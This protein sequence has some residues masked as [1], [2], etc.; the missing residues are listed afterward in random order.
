MMTPLECVARQLAGVGGRASLQRARV[1]LVH[2]LRRCMSQSAPA[3]A[4]SAS[5]PPVRGAIPSK[6]ALDVVDRFAVRARIES[7][8]DGGAWEELCTLTE[9]HL[10]AAADKYSPHG[11]GADELSATSNSRVRY[12][13]GTELSTLERAVVRLA[14]PRDLGALR[15]AEGPVHAVAEARVRLKCAMK[16]VGALQEGAFPATSA[17]LERIAHGARASRDVRSYRH[18]LALVRANERLNGEYA[19]AMTPAQLLQARLLGWW[20]PLPPQFVHGRTLDA[21][22]AEAAEQLADPAMALAKVGLLLKLLH[23][24]SR[25]PSERVYCAAL[26]ACGRAGDG[27]AVW[28]LF[29]QL[30]CAAGGRPPPPH[31]TEAEAA[32]LSAGGRAVVLHLQGRR[33][34]IEGDAVEG[35]PRLRADTFAAAISGLTDSAYAHA[36]SQG[37]FHA[38]ALDAAQKRVPLVLGHMLQA[39]VP[40][41]EATL[42]CLYRLVTVQTNAKVEH[43]DKDT[44]ARA[45]EV[46]IAGCTSLGIAPSPGM[47]AELLNGELNAGR[48]DIAHAL[49]A[50]IVDAA[51]ERARRLDASVA[52]AGASVGVQEAQTRPFALLRTQPAS[53]A[54]SRPSQGTEVATRSSLLSTELAAWV[55]RGLSTSEVERRIPDPA[56]GGLLPGTGRLLHVEGL[57]NRVLQRALLRA[58]AHGQDFHRFSLL[59]SDVLWDGGSAQRSF[60]P[61]TLRYILMGLR[62]HPDDTARLL[63]ALLAPGLAMKLPRV[64]TAL[65]AEV[66]AALC[67]DVVPGRPRRL[68]PSTA[69]SI[70]HNA[71]ARALDEDRSGAHAGVLTHSRLLSLLPSRD[72]VGVDMPATADATYLNR[73]TTQDVRAMGLAAAAH[74]TSTDDGGRLSHSL[75]WYAVARDAT[76]LVALALDDLRPDGRR[77]WH[78]AC[79]RAGLLLSSFPHALRAL[80]AS[81]SFALT[82]AE[83]AQT[84]LMSGVGGADHSA[85][86]QLRVAAEKAA[87]YSTRAGAHADAAR[88]VRCLRESDAAGTQWWTRREAG[89]DDPLLLPPALPAV[90]DSPALS[91]GSSLSASA[92]RAYEAGALLPLVRSGR[93]LMR[94]LHPLPLHR[95]RS[96]EG[97]GAIAHKRVWARYYFGLKPARRLVV[98]AGIPF[99]HDSPL[100][101]TVL[102]P[103]AVQWAREE[104]QRGRVPREGGGTG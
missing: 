57:R 37:A 69:L 87:F 39:G 64:D 68:A 67:A 4:R 31:L 59:A 6:L 85:I 61:V 51:E 86:N 102:A 22:L 21:A 5:A 96:E 43:R 33:A 66:L 103:A 25:S 56:H 62:G 32:A 88:L 38:A 36:S 46:L 71:L 93:T 83:V 18:L 90:P 12:F 2:V 15:H 44:A 53:T 49:S 29:E 99:P 82:L 76:P 89:G 30:Q 26:R 52:D 14:S 16:L 28:R 92:V 42:H 94:L 101:T 91:D 48:D 95:R 55:L 20:G 35:P 80:L 100:V 17:V 50:L 75:R 9:R 40:A 97:G 58:L 81:P 34:S 72:G 60:D 23:A 10:R 41:G 79:S 65:C 3:A 74:L 54:G 77:E 73:V 1:T 104:V 98:R 78:A 11:S 27:E 7:L 24:W 13:E 63:Q 47:L 19:D 84:A 45:V 8:A 70:A